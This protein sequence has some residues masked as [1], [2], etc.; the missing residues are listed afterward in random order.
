MSIDGIMLAAIKKDLHENLLNGRID[1]IYQLDKYEITLL[2]RNNNRNYKI[3]VSAHPN[4]PRVH[5]TEENFKHPLKAPDFCMLLRKYLL[6]GTI[7]S[8]KQPEFERIL[9]IEIKLYDNN[10][11]LII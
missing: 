5:I 4:Y 10:Y 9:N 2:I 7:T 11:N 6:R 1:K 3:L 8:I